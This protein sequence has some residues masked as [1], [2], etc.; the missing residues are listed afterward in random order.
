MGILNH[1]ILKKNYHNYHS[2][3]FI[4]VHWLPNLVPIIRLW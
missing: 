1:P 3:P 2:S 4:G